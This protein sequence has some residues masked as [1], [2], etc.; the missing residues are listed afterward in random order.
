[1][2]RVSIRIFAARCFSQPGQIAMSED[3]H[4][5][6]QDEELPFLD[7]LDH[8][9]YQ[10]QMWADG[11]G[12]LGQRKL[13]NARVLISRVGGVGGVVAYELAAAGVGKLVL[14]HGG[15]IKHSD[16][17]RQLLMT[18]DRLGQS[19]VETAKQRLLQLNPRI[20]VDV[21]DAN[22]NDENVDA[23]VSQVDI[24]VDC[25]PIFEERYAMNRAIVA[26]GKPMVECAMFELE[27]SITTILPGRTPCLACLSPNPPPA[28]RRQFPVFG[29]VSGTVGCLA[30]VEVIKLITGIGESL[31]GTLLVMDL[32][33]MTFSRRKIHQDMECSICSV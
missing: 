30:A 19:R 9:I 11:V 17:N 8:T 25:A 18:Y 22:I 10:W 29:A 14:A 12:E 5:G 23:L 3:V 28:W 2:H 33:S 20:Q 7:D 21:V 13:K 31:A 6:D 16:L 15:K 26:Q 1:M 32:A 24:V 4:V 27:G